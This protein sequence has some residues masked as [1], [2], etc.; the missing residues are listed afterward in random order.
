MNKTKLAASQGLAVWRVIREGRAW[1]EIGWDNGPLRI[2]GGHA[3]YQAVLYQCGPR[4]GKTVLLAR[5]G[6]Y[7]GTECRGLEQHNRRV[8]PDT[9]LEFLA[10]N[11]GLTLL[12]NL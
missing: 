9:V 11:K 10:P 7:T 5:L 4:Q 3:I 2:K 8:Q 6:T 1:D 12:S